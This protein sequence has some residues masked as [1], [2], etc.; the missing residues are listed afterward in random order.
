M[1]S[2]KVDEAAARAEMEAKAKYM[3][4]QREKLVAMKQKERGEQMAN[5]AKQQGYTQPTPSGGARPADGDKEHRDMTRALL[6]RF[7]D[8]LVH[9]STMP[10]SE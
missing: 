1:E 10:R 7:K 8:D 2:K 6:R 4:E 5:Y 9:E 3:R